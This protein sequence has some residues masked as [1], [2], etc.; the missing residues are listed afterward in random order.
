LAASISFPMQHSRGYLIQRIL[1]SISELAPR[2]S[3]IGSPLI[4]N[5]HCSGLTTRFANLARRCRN[6][7]AQEFTEE[8][9]PS[10][11]CGVDSPH[12]CAS[13]ITP[14]TL[15]NEYKGRTCRKPVVRCTHSARSR[16]PCGEPLDFG[17][18]V[19]ISE[20]RGLVGPAYI[21][22]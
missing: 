1:T 8:L 18:Q 14:N 19:M 13:T 2:Y 7:D 9:W 22:P 10:R 20:T 3:R 21:K 17:S 15:C 11:A 16:Y 4:E 5:A 12:G 6:C